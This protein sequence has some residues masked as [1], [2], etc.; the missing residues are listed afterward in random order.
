MQTFVPHGPL[1][2]ET[3]RTLDMKR[4]G[5]QRVEV[6]QIIRALTGEQK[7]WRHHPAVKMWDG[8]ELALTLY[9]IAMCD[10]WIKRGYKDSLK[11]K[12]TVYLKQFMDDQQT[13]EFPRWLWDSDVIKSHRSNL[14]R[15]YADHYGPMW[16][17]TPNDL[18]YVWPVA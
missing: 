13:M 4:L 7:G 9:G 17:D 11:P 12:L 6:Y 15:K 16:P 10:E 1:F 2:S 18:P 5:K 14:I 8:Y 3:A